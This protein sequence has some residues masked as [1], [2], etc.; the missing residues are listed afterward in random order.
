MTH[1][2][3]C[4]CSACAREDWTNPNLAHCGVHGPSC[5]REYA[6]AADTPDP[7]P[8]SP[9]P[10][11]LT[12]IVPTDVITQVR[13]ALKGARGLAL[14]HD[15]ADLDIELEAAIEA[16]DAARAAP[17]ADAGTLREGA[18]IA[19]AVRRVSNREAFKY[20]NV[21][22]TALGAALVE[23]WPALAASSPATAGRE[24]GRLAAALQSEDVAEYLR[25]IASNTMTS[26]RLAPGF[27]H[28]FAIAILAAETP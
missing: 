14:D 26:G 19:T 5:P 18:A 27:A 3:H 25:L 20:V 1:G 12:A 23:E 6:P 22:W 13:S 16:L 2:R 28:E 17:Q 24:V 7:R 4:P 10:S 11:E 21:D 9:V 8:V 15:E